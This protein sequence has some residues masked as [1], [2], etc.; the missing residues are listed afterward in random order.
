MW[1]LDDLVRITDTQLK[2]I[3]LY[4][5]SM[6]VYKYAKPALERTIKCFESSNNKYYQNMSGGLREYHSGQYSIYLWYL[7][8]EAYLAGDTQ[9]AD[10]LYCL[11]KALHAVDW[12]YAIELPLHWNVEHPVGSVL[13]RGV[14]GDGLYIYQNCTIGGSVRKTGVAYPIIGRNVTLMAYSSILGECNIGDNVVLAA[15]TIVKNQDVP[16]CALVVGQSPNLII[17]VKDEN[18]FLYARGE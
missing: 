11:N 2:N 17:K 6:A 5:N 7:S 4:S 10:V 8:N 3:F 13:D 18:Y 16:N 1:G 15:G 9:C 14:Y 12:L